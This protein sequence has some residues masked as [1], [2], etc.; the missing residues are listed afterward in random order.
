MK[1]NKLIAEFMG[2]T[3]NEE[4]VYQVSKHKGYDVEN[5]HYHISWDWLM[6][7]V[8]KIESLGYHVDIVKGWTTII[9]Q[10]EDRVDS[11]DIQ[12]C[13]TNKK[14]ATYKAV[15][16]FIKKYNWQH[17]NSLGKP[18]AIT[19]GKEQDTFKVGDVINPLGK[20]IYYRITWTDGYGNLWEVAFTNNPPKWLEENNKDR[21][22]DGDELEKLDDFNI[23][24]VATYIY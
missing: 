7:V 1:E 14:E 18:N 6:P 13:D 15:V 20:D 12:E 3:P 21:I 2:I 24:S 11:K 10:T 4:G 22:A 16:E 23:T 17:F 8:E 9:N 19:T 5:L